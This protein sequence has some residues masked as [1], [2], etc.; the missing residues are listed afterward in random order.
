MSSIQQDDEE[1]DPGEK[2]LASQMIKGKRGSI[3]VGE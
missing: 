3:T 1:R 2:D